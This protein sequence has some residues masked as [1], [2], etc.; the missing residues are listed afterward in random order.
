MENNLTITAAKHQSELQTWRE[1]VLACRTSGLLIKDW[2][3]QNQVSLAT[4]YRWQKA[5]WDYAANTLRPAGQEIIAV[6]MPAATVRF[7]ELQV[8]AYMKEQ[9]SGA[10]IVVKR[11]SWTVEIS[12]SASSELIERIMRVVVSHG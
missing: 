2:C 5:V 8:P 10:D 11:E 4:Y 9:S 6:D 12:N 3:A 1:R 7:A